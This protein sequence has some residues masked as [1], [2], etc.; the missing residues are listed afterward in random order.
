MVSFLT[1]FAKGVFDGIN[2]D[3]AAKRQFEYDSKI[4]EAKE[5]A[6]NAP[7]VVEF[8]NDGI[9]SYTYNTADAGTEDKDYYNNVSLGN[10]VTESSKPRAEFG[11]KSIIQHLNERQDY[12]AL[13][14]IATVAQ[15]HMS[16]LL[17]VRERK[18]GTNYITPLTV[19]N[20]RNDFW[21]GIVK[22]SA[23]SS[24]GSALVRNYK[25]TLDYLKDNN[26][27]FGTIDKADLNGNLTREVAHAI[28]TDSEI[29]AKDDKGALTK[30]KM[31]VGDIVKFL[32]RRAKQDG[33]TGLNQE[34]LRNKV[35]SKYVQDTATGLP[36][37]ERISAEMSLQNLFEDGYK[38]GLEDTYLRGAETI[39]DA[40]PQKV[41]DNPNLVLDIFANAFSGE[42]LLS[43]LVSGDPSNKFDTFAKLIGFKDGSAEALQQKI[44][45]IDKPLKRVTDIKTM[46]A[47]GAP[48]ESQEIGGTATTIKFIDGVVNQVN[49]AARAL[50]ADEEEKRSG[51]L[52]TIQGLFDS[53]NDEQVEEAKKLD[54]T[55]NVLYQKLQSTSDA[56][57][58]ATPDA[59]NYEDLKKAQAIA[60]VQYQSFLLAFEMAAA[61]QGGGDSRTISNKDVE[62]MLTALTISAFTSTRT[63]TAILDQIERDL[64]YSKMINEYSEKALSSGQLKKLKAFK[65]IEN[66]RYRVKNRAQDAFPSLAEKYMTTALQGRYSS[67][68]AAKSEL[69][70]YGIKFP[71]TSI[72]GGDIPQDVFSKK[73]TLNGV[74]QTV[75]DHF[76]P[77][78][79]IESEEEAVEYLTDIVGAIPKGDL[80]Q[81]RQDLLTGWRAIQEQMGLDTLDEVADYLPEGIVSKMFKDMILDIENN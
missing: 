68:D 57:R 66:T 4:A 41:R 6:K 5:K 3:A 10:L 76:E 81:Y 49:L 15:P 35:L 23:E 48:L 11:G 8:Y 36:V 61:V 42:N 9:N 43:E 59:A 40:L 77:L 14:N 31:Q 73:I 44:A 75:R 1:G 45:N 56:L 30:R 62:L 24:G 32:D 79:Q 46:F 28:T 17:K 63:F 60:V 20:N 80:E 74:T 27:F 58:N 53:D 13:Q 26:T 54:K 19:L 78:A 67:E 52:N 29:F 37:M 64:K 69:N 50:G 25:K 18:D 71:D 70:K 7:N 65:V 38:E 12:D 34:D 51:V 16:A 22:P 21:T 47:P 72:L 39:L 55:Q 33:L 2:E